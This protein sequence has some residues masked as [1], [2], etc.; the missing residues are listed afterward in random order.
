MNKHNVLLTTL[1]CGIFSINAVANTADSTVPDPF[2]RF[3][4]NSRLTIDY[5]DLDSLL[6]AL[7]LYTGRSDRSKART[8]QSQ[9]GTRM[10][11]SVN[12]GNC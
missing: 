10:K 2:Q 3:D 9:T 1:F 5:T 7:V 8:S 4:D 11:F 6:E 12:K